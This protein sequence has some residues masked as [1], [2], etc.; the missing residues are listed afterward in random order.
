MTP[1]LRN[2]FSWSV[3]RDS[4]L[5][6]CP[7]KY[8]FSYYGSWG[9]WEPEAP[10]RVR[11]IYLLKKLK[12][13]PL[14]IGEVVHDCIARSLLNHSRGIPV[15][16]LEQI[17][18][19]TRDRMR[20]DFRHSRAG[21]YRE[22]PASYT[23]L[24]EHEYEVEVSDGEWRAAAEQVDRCLM[25]FYESE[26]YQ[27]FSRMDADNF[28]EI[29]KF[30]SFD[31]D[32]VKIHVRLDCAVRDSDRVVVWD[33]KTGKSAR[34]G[35]PLQLACYAW[36]AGGAFD[37]NP[38]RVLTRQYELYEDTV[39]EQALTTRSFEELFSYMRGSIS[40]MRGLLDDPDKNRASE[41]KF[42]KVNRAGTCLRC[43]FLKVCKPDI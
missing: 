14:W 34:P 21:R 37:L 25:N 2:E 33:W 1:S 31:L 16:P 20:Q 32:G 23:G 40:D 28:L 19:I 22:N 8:Y 30:S 12:T 5:Q 26:H 7:R 11:E 10:A 41:E 17:L 4:T 3:S 6:E 38:T 36:Y 35:F 24:F 27:R 42:A 13:R 39:H 9:G 43:N 29:E 15:L 18:S